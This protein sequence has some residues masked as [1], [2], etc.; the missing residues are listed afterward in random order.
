[1]MRATL[2]RR[3]GRVSRSGEVLPQVEGLRCLAIV[4]VVLFHA[5]LFFSVKSGLSNADAASASVVSWVLQQGHVGVQLFFVIS[6]FV[7]AL[8]YCR[9]YLPELPRKAPPP[10]T[11]AYFVRRLSRLEPPYLVSLVLCYVG[12]VL[13]GRYGAGEL[14][15]HLLASSIYMH[16]VTFGS[17]SLVN[18]VAWS[19]EIELQFYVLLPLLASVLLLPMRRRRFMLGA[20]IVASLGMNFFIEPGTVANRSILAFLHYF[21]AG[22]L[23]ADVV[24]AQGEIV[25]RSVAW[26]VVGCVALA[27][28]WR[29]AAHYEDPRLDAALLLAISV[30]FL[31]AFFGRTSGTV[32]SWWPACLLGGMC[33]SIYLVHYPLIS[34][35]GGALLPFRSGHWAVDVLILPALTFVPVVFVSAMFYLA[36]ERPTMAPNWWRRMSSGESIATSWRRSGRGSTQRTIEAAESRRGTDLGSHTHQPIAGEVSG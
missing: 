22:V 25:A 15:P 4:A 20:M 21:V 23:F 10:S 29:L 32:L 35:I 3:F 36:V 2:E 33:Y 28:T 24:V 14:L 17:M 30:V 9:A 13:R 12:L 8:P 5:E 26:D 6:G 18:G 16:T 1:M 7:L 11:R 34:L 31:S 19:L 27:A